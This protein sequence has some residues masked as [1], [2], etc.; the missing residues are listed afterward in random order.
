M[1]VELSVPNKLFYETGYD[2]HS[3]GGCPPCCLGVRVFIPIRRIRKVQ[4]EETNVLVTL[5]DI[6]DFVF[7]EI[8]LVIH[9]CEHEFPHIPPCP[10]MV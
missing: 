8:L 6:S 7:I 3:S 10:Q 1:G 4:I 5:D 9:S 2:E